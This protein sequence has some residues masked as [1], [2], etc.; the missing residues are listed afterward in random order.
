MPA[1]SEDE[2]DALSDP[3]V[4]VNFDDIPALSSQRCHLSTPASTSAPAQ[5]SSRAAEA[6]DT[7]SEYS[8]FDE[9][10]SEAL[11][12]LDRIEANPGAAP[13]S[14]ASSRGSIQTV[15]TAE[16]QSSRYFISSPTKPTA[17]PSSPEP[18]LNKHKRKAS[19]S[20]SGTL[21]SS[22]AKRL[23]NNS[24][25]AISP[26]GRVRRILNTF[27]DEMTCP[28]CCDLIA[29]AH[30]GNPCGHTTCGE[31]LVGW[32]QKSTG[33]ATCPIC[34]ATLSAEQPLIP[35]FA[36]DNTLEKQVSALGMN[37]DRDWTEGGKKLLEWRA[38]KDKWKEIAAKRASKAG[39][40]PRRNA[41]ALEIFEVVNELMG[42]DAEDEDYESSEIESTPSEEGSLEV[43]GEAAMPAVVPARV[44]RERGMQRTRG[45]GQPS[46]TRGRRRRREG[47]P[48]TGSRVRHGGG[49]RR[50]R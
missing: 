19:T 6:D 31:C 29:A 36:L 33:G 2:F 46:S 28:I 13:K 11:A 10:D 42:D 14:V 5:S 1:A 17:R 20:S 4:G 3:F 21:S 8:M 45:P 35:N 32:I 37:G 44:H 24:I 9:L 41:I 15:T 27:E 23:K 50:R 26:N 25:G 7:S 43:T 12:T 49:G 47:E 16:R 18:S 40:R 48:A 22:P 34:R 39:K 30:L 38:R